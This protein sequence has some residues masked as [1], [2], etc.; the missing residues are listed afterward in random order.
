MTDHASDGQ[1]DQLVK[2]R[3]LAV[4]LSQSDLAEVLDAVTW[5][6]G[7]D[8]GQP[9]NAASAR[10]ARIAEALEVPL[11]AMDV[12]PS[13]KRRPVIQEFDPLRALLD[14]QL[15]RAFRKLEDLRTRRLLVQL[16]EQLVKR[17]VKRR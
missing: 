13:D 2:A 16:A 8:A 1:I 9:R 11:G 7:E 6:T 15:L 12:E 4:G 17:Q 14:L 3:W 10:V 5:P